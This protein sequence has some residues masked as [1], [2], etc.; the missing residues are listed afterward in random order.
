MKKEGLLLLVSILVLACG[1]SD[2]SP[3]V[4]KVDLEVS[5]MTLPNISEGTSSV[6]FTSNVS[7]SL[8]LTD[9]RAVPDWFDVTP[10]AGEAGT[11]KL[12]LQ[13][14]KPN[15]TF[16]DRQ[17]YIRICAGTLSK[18]VTVIQEKKES[19][20]LNLTES[21]VATGGGVIDVELVTNLD[22]Q[23]DIAEDSREWLTQIK[24]KGL[25]TSNLRFSASENLS[26]LSRTG[27]ITFT[28]GS[29]VK[30]LTVIQSGME[31][32]V[33]LDLSSKN[34]P[35]ASGNFSVT[36]TSNT[37]WSANDIP[38]WLTLDQSSGNGDTILDI[39]YE[40]NTST[41]PRSATISF[42]AGEVTQTLLVTQAGAS[43]MLSL[44]FSVKSVSSA[45]GYFTMIVTSNTS[46]ISS[47]I[48]SWIKLSQAS[49]NGN[50]NISINYQ[51]NT[52]GKSRSA[53]IT[54]VAGSIINTLT[55]TQKNSQLDDFEEEEL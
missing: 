9:T 20:N 12:I 11:A 46:W 25:S 52:L 19:L 7:W 23:I 34:V 36:L 51:A 8:D 14:K 5:E 4:P 16:D 37:S 3:I 2:E 26:I 21:H 15:E 44:Q 10:K 32:I 13:I 39:S 31:P 45:S 55:I 17:A 6:T 33:S 1:G 24:T 30:T 48:P 41:S 54:F 40:P 28:A 49:G 18:V 43:P 22:Y 47:G 53:T 35:S 50:T 27:V 42:V 29:I 38:S